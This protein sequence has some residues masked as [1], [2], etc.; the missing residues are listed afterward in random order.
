[1]SKRATA[2]SHISPERPALIGVILRQN[3][4]LIPSGFI[5]LTVCESTTRDKDKPPRLRN[6]LNTDQRASLH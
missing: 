5:D 4:C 2:N 1:M 3:Y 6:N